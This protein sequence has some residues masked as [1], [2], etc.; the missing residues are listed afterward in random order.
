MTA[1]V[2][3]M[4]AD[5]A[6]GGPRRPC[7]HG[8]PTSPSGSSASASTR[9]TDS[10]CRPTCSTRTSHCSALPL[11]PRPH[12]RDVLARFP[13]AFASRWPSS[14]A[15]LRLDACCRRS[16]A[17]AFERLKGLLVASASRAAST[18][19]SVVLYASSYVRRGSAASFVQYRCFCLKAAAPLATVIRAARVPA[20]RP[21]C[22]SR[23]PR[24]V[25][26]LATCRLSSSSLVALRRV[27]LDAGRAPASRLADTTCSRPRRPPWVAPV[28]MPPRLRRC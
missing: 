4:I 18:P 27:G 24:R 1:V 15:R 19:P 5:R 23:P 21:R 2:R 28:R 20:A 6:H 7:D 13:L 17:V 22:Q 8:P 9:S 3:R 16:E 12:D 10:T 14:G 25:G 26:T 11:S